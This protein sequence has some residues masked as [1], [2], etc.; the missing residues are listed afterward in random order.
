MLLSD[1][2]LPQK[3]NFMNTVDSTGLIS[4]RGG[5]P[6]SGRVN[7]SIPSSQRAFGVAGGQQRISKLAL[8]QGNRLYSAENT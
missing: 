8:D 6:T 2:F 3:N 1:A 7:T 5:Q 4:P